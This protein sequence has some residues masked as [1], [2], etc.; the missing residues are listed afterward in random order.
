[1][2]GNEIQGSRPSPDENVL[3]I[4]IVDKNL[5]AVPLSGQCFSFPFSHFTSYQFSKFLSRS[6]TCSSSL[7]DSQV[8]D[9]QVSQVFLKSS[10]CSVCSSEYHSLQVSF[11]V[12]LPPSFPSLD[13]ESPRLSSYSCQDFGFKSPSLHILASQF[14]PSLFVTPSPGLQY[15]GRPDVHCPRIPDSL[16]HLV[17]IKSPSLSASKSESSLSTFVV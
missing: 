5:Q 12:G 6:V 13:H 9:V 16:V 15:P 11:S 10:R 17:S 4:C 14:F 7:A 1:M 8:P 3:Q 2:T